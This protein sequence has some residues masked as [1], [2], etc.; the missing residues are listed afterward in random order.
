MIRAAT[1]R[2]AEAIAAIY[3]FYIAN[4]T[5][6]FE[7]TELPAAEIATRIEAVGDTGYPWLAFERDGVVLGYAYAG[8]FAARSGYRLTAEGTVYVAP[9]AR[10]AGIGTELYRELIDR[11]RANGAH[12]VLGI[13]ALPNEPSVRLHEKLGFVKVA[14]LKEIGRKFERWIDVGYWQLLL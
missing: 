5:V 12:C 13:I 6:T 3:N 8:R 14:D 1:S 7:E 2:D 4:T 10:G 9:D 11:L